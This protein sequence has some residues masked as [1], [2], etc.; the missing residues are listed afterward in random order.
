M[1]NTNEDIRKITVN[2]PASLIDSAMANNNKGLTET[3][4]EAL[5]LYRRKMLFTK[6]ENLR[7]KIDFGATWQELKEDRE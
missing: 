3:I 4:R 7:G 2:L 6:L 1:K 5:E